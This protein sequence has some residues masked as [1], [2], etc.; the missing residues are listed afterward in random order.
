[1]DALP[2]CQHIGLVGSEIALCA[3]VR[4]AINP[5]P[6]VPGFSEITLTIAATFLAAVIGGALGA[7]GGSFAFS[8][9]AAG[10]QRCAGP[11]APP[12]AFDLDDPMQRKE[13]ERLN[14]CGHDR[15]LGLN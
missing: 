7:F 14:P 8:R 13:F 11:P 3:S 12:T 15:R 2:H 6:P 1:M 9:L 5:P 10:A 4:Q